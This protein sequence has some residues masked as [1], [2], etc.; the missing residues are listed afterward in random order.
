MNTPPRK[1]TDDVHSH[2]LETVKRYM[3]LNGADEA[4]LRTLRYETRLLNPDED[5]VCQ[6]ERPEVSVYI[7]NGALARYH[8]LA[9]GDRQFLS[10]H[11]SK[12][13]PDVQGLFLKIMDHSVC[14]LI[15]SEIVLFRHDV[16]IPL[17][18]RRP[19]ICFALWR[20]TL[21][22]AA[23]FRQAITNNS[24]RPPEARIAH[25]CCEQFVRAR[26]AGLASED[27]CGFP[28]TQIQLGQMLGISLVTVNRALQAL[29]SRRLLDIR[30]GRLMIKNW[31]GLVRVANFDESYLHIAQE[32]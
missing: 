10:M 14:A 28:L 1:D 2:L 27:A 16:L 5:I 20:I 29:R 15:Q 12:D 3:P 26:D 30:D 4:A 31:R 11:I 24:A 18:T 22:D 23:I 32:S 19:N 8:T 13:L 7:L 25:F 6:G 17:V 9:N 21:V